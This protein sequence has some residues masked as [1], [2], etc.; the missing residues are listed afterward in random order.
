M[1]QKCYTSGADFQL[2]SKA[3]ERYP[4][5]TLRMEG[6]VYAFGLDDVADERGGIS[7]VGDTGLHVL[8][9][10]SPAPLSCDERVFM[11]SGWLNADP[12]GFALR[13]GA[14]RWRQ[15][16]SSLFLC[17]LGRIHRKRGCALLCVHGGISLRPVGLLRA[18]ATW[19]C[20]LSVG[21]PGVIDC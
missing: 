13:S 7:A 10:G 16:L 15:I 21:S 2:N 9:E 6:A 18:D 19:D 12:F 20:R 1:A 5:G 17:I 14:T 4:D 11:P 8:E 3:L